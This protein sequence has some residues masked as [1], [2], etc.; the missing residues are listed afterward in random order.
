MF[1]PYGVALTM[2]K[3]RFYKYSIPLGLFLPFSLTPQIFNPAGIAFAVLFDP[4]NIQSRWD[5]LRR[6]I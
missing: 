3:I 2:L 6:F 5:R 4:T 1:D